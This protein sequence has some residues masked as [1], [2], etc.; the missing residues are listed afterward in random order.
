VT[1]AL[2]GGVSRPRC[3]AVRAAGVPPAVQFNI[4]GRHVTVDA[5]LEQLVKAK[6]QP[7]L[8]LLRGAECIEGEGG[9]HDCDVKLM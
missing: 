6:L 5:A 8:D 9:V 3:V 1:D 7:A 4:H 2:Q